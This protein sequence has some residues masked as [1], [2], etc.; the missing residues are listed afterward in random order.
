[1]SRKR[2]TSP[3]G[4]KAVTVERAARLY[5][6]LHL[7]GAEPRSR[8]VILQRLRVD[9]RTFYRDL[10]LLRDY[11]ID[12]RLTGRKYVL[13]GKVSQLLD[14]LPLPDPGLT[15]GEAKQLSKGR[16]AAHAKLRKLVKQIAG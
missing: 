3:A 8:A 9:I 1:M 12:V 2:S 6:L 13:H 10:E 4:S 11:G 7:L 15:L 16:T 5:R 14:A